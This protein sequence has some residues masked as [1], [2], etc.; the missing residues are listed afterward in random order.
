MAF[1]EPIQEILA[2]IKV[3]GVGGGGQNAVTS[4]VK[5][6]KLEGVE[7]IAVNTDKQALDASPV[8]IRLQIGKK[9]TRGLGSGADPVV[10]REAAEES[11]DELR[12]NLQGSDM[13]FIAACLG[14]GTGT[15]AAPIVA[16]VARKQGALTVGVVTKPFPFEGQRRMSQAE[17]GIRELK[18]RVD[19]LIVIPNERLLD[20][21]DESVP[22]TD[23]FLI[24]DEVIGNAVEGISELI[25]S[26]GLVN[27]DF[28]DVKTI[29]TNAGSALMGVGF[30][31]GEDRAEKAAKMAI[32]S[33]LLDVDVSGSTGVL[34][35]VVGD[36][37]LTMHEVNTAARIV[38][39]A[40]HEGANI[41][42]GANIDSSIEGIKVTVIATGFETDFASLSL[43]EISSSVDETVL[44]QIDSRFSNKPDDEQGENIESEYEEIDIISSSAMASMDKDSDEFDIDKMRKEIAVLDE[45]ENEDGGDKMGEEKQEDDL[46]VAKNEKEENKNKDKEDNSAVYDFMSAQSDYKN[47]HTKTDDDVSGSSD[48]SN[49]D[50]GTSDKDT[51]QKSDDDN[52]EAKGKPR[53]STDFWSFIKKKK[54]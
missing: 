52:D 6:K 40:S 36:T 23:A 2:R 32:E 41:I 42:F 26:T 18:E 43:P 38:S 21:V 22:L 29:M 14:G 19:A 33:P 35:N 27:V 30:A 25:T 45:D 50:H 10:G 8:P 11:I 4:M 34:I 17:Q 28:A 53:A 1:I 39:E 31:Q 15:G 48:Y 51:S 9:R 46:E 7:F 37:S 49:S 44:D 20:I 12:S 5:R 16:E 47:S 3:V 24:A 13:I 54:I